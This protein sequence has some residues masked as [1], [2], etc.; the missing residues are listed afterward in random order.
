MNYNIYYSENLF[1]ENSETAII[2]Q[3]VIFGDVDSDG[4]YDG[5]DAVTVSMIAGEMLTRE[6]V[7]EAVWMEA[8]CNHDGVIYQLDVDLLNQAGVLLSSVDQTKPT[9]ELLETSSEYSE[10]LNLIIQET[11]NISNE[12]TDNEDN[13]ETPV[14]SSWEVFSSISLI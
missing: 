7:G 12:P 3:A 11:D 10:Y 8:D 1:D 5:Q 14:L 4:W 9:D 13:T 6:R 2:H